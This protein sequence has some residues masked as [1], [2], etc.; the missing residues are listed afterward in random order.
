MGRSRK[1]SASAQPRIRDVLIFP[2]ASGCLAIASTALL[3]AIPIPTPAPIPVS[4]A[5]P[6]PIAIIVPL[7]ICSPFLVLSFLILNVVNV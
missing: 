6:A 7:I 3:V 5:I 2:S 1:H 4:T